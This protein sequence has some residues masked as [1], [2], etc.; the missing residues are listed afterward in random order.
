MTVHASYVVPLKL[1]FAEYRVMELIL[2]RLQSLR[3]QALECRKTV[4]EQ[5]GSHSASTTDAGG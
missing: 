2:G 4:W 3:D 5:G 1:S